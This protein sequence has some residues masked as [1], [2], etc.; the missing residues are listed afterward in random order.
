MTASEIT[1]L[2]SG[3]LLA[4]SPG[5]VV[6][7]VAAL[8]DAT[9]SDA[10]FF[11]NALYL[12]ALRVSQA[13]VALVPE[14][15]SEPLPQV[16][17]VVGVAHPSLAFAQ[18][19]AVLQPP[20]P[21]AAA[22]IHATAVIDPAATV[23]R[24]VCIQAYVVIE[25][26]ARIAD[27][28][29][30]GAH[31]FVG[32][33]SAIGAHSLIHPHVTIRERVQIGERC[34]VHSG[35]V[36]GGDGFGFETVNGKHVKIPQVGGVE[37]GNDVEIGA[38]VAI[39]RARFGMTRIGDGTKIDNLVQIA[40]NVV[41]GPGCLVVA[42]VGISG[43]THLGKYVVLAGQVGVV[44]HIKIGDGAI[45]G[46]QSGVSKNVAA[47]EK[48][49]GSPAEPMRTATETLARVRRLPKLME[50]VK[51]LEAELAALKARA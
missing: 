43:S 32:R 46:A 16:G 27:G 26:G 33:E 1:R 35:S 8:D 25:S 37:I 50:R 2:V 39:D 24:D 19:V 47:G 17:A 34:I 29:H 18:V 49:F 5:T 40:H 41:I 42:Q 21:P 44:G 28:V 38:C 10:T 51:A 7:G 9:A 36:L 6:T 14:D 48:V 12:P 20:L 15:F 30:L 23:G 22:G 11:G 31:A 4:G 3:R 45:V 13:G